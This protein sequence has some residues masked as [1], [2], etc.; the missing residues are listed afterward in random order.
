MRIID[1]CTKIVQKEVPMIDENGK[2]TE[3]TEMKD[4][5][6]V[7]GESLTGFKLMIW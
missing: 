4:T 2:P 6:Q 3:E 5:V 1:T 7:Q